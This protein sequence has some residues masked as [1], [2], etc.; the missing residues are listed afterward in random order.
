MSSM[1]R[2]SA[3]GTMMGVQSATSIII[4]DF[5]ATFGA[6]A[7]LLGTIVTKTISGL[8]TTDA[9]QVQCLSAPPSGMIIANARVSA[10]D[11][12]EIL[13]STSI[14]IGITLGSLNYRLIVAR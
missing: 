8:L 5:T 1:S 6:I 7:A 14:A 9:V 4:V 10:A 12:L 13:F 2:G 11:T 3:L